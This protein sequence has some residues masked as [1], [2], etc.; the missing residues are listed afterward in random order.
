MQLEIANL[1][2]RFNPK[3]NFKLIFNNQLPNESFF[4]FKDRI[5]YYLKSCVVY[6]LSCGQCASTFIGE[7]YRHLSTRI[8]EH[9]G[10][11]VGT[12]QTLS[13]PPNSSIRDRTLQAGHHINTN[14]FQNY[15]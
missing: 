4:N 9:K 11:S 6:K 5:P 10:I 2:G 14:F 15:S 8:A 13:N 1:L 12:G 3:N 7:T